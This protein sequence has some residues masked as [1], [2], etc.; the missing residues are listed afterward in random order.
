MQVFMVVNF[1]SYVISALINLSLV[2]K[3]DRDRSFFLYLC[4]RKKHPLNSHGAMPPFQSYSPE[5]PGDL[6]TSNC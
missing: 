6:K 3:F 1:S 2:V 4:P 5:H